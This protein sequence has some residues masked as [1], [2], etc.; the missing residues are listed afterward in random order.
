M[1]GRFLV[2]Y[3]FTNLR[4]RRLEAKTNV[5]HPFSTPGNMKV[6]IIFP[7]NGLIGAS[8]IESNANGVVC[9]K[10]GLLWTNV[11]N[12]RFDQVKSTKLLDLRLLNL[13]VTFETNSGNLV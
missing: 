10:T 12:V 5:T 7:L 3:G 4:F 13:M 2:D 1:N 8:R 6:F 9:S 11:S